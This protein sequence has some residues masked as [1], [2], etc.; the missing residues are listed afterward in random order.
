[1]SFPDF[2]TFF[3]HAS[4]HS[5][6]PWQERLAATAC[7]GRWP[8][9]I[10]IPTGL[11]KTGTLSIALY[12]LAS[13]VHAGR[14]RTTPQRII[15]VVDRRPVVDQTHLGL[16]S[17]SRQL[18]ASGELAPV[19]AALRRL[20]GPWGQRGDALVVQGI[21]G[22]SRDDRR[23]LRPTG[24]C[25]VT[26]TPHQLVSRLLFRG[27]GVSARTRS[28]HAG[29]LGVDA[30]I[31][32][33]EPH[34]S[35]QAIATVRAVLELQADAGA[36]LGLP[37]SRLVLLGATVPGA[38]DDLGWV[39]GLDEDDRRHSQLE[40]VLPASRPVRLVTSGTS[41]SAVAGAL[42]REYTA[43]RKRF[44]ADRRIAVMANTVSLAQTVRARLCALET[45]QDEAEPP[46]IPLVTS[47]MR[48]H[49][50]TE[51]IGSVT[52]PD[53]A[54]TVVAT[55]SLEVGID[56][57]F[58]TL[59]TEACPYPA[60]VQ[61]L[62]R[63]NRS[64]ESTDA[65]AVVVIGTDPAQVRKGTEAVYGA[66]AVEATTRMLAG[67]AVEGVV[68]LSLARQLEL[69]DVEAASTDLWPAQARLATFHRDYLAVMATTYP[70]PWSDL[71]VDSFVSG[72]DE[73]GLEVLV[74]WRSDLG[75]L[76]SCPPLSAEQV[77]VPLPALRAMLADHA[78]VEVAD[79]D[80]GASVRKPP[81][82]R[83]SAIDARVRR[84]DT[85]LPVQA[86]W[87]LPGDVVVLGCR[88][89]GYLPDAGWTPASST[90]VPDLSLLAALNAGG[91]DRFPVSWESLSPWLATLGL[92]GQDASEG[93]LRAVD[94]VLARLE[95]LDPDE[96]RAEL[97]QAAPS[98]A[99][100]T[101]VF[102]VAG[103]EEGL[104]LLARTPAKDMPGD[105]ASTGN[106]PGLGRHQEQV[107]KEV[108]DAA[109][110]AGM[111]EAVTEAVAVA[112]RWHDE[113][114]S[115]ARFQA[116]LGNPYP[117]DAWAK[118]RRG[119][120][121]PGTD[122]R[123][124]A[125][126]GLPRGWRH[127]GLSAQLCA[128]Q[129]HSE[130]A[131]HLVGSHH[132]RF[133]PLLHADATDDGQAELPARAEAFKRLNAT[134]GPWGLAYLEAMLR[135]SDWHA[136]Q[137]PKHGPVTSELPRGRRTVAVQ[138]GRG[139]C[140]ETVLVGLTPSPLTGWF[141]LAGLLRLV[142]EHD[143]ATTIHWP[144]EGNSPPMAPVWSSS[145]PVAEACRLLTTS[146]QW[147]ELVER[148]RGRTGGLAAKYQKV[149]A[150]Q[151]DLR[152]A[153]DMGAWLVTGILQD[154]A[155]ADGQRL[156]LSIPAQANNAS[157][158][159]TALDVCRDGSSPGQ[160]APEL[161][162]CL[163]DPLSGWREAQCDGGMDRAGTEDGVTGR[164]VK[165]HR[166]IRAELAPAALMGMASMGAVGVQGLGVRGRSLRLPLP[167]APVTWP[168]LVA[169]THAVSLD[170]GWVLCY[171]A[172][173]VTAYE[174]LWDGRAQSSRT[175]GN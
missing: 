172:R 10:D 113:G 135:L 119:R 38:R 92:E 173:K 108:L 128:D 73:E 170:Q 168:E 4:G 158:V 103:S 146:D 95:E 87:I 90:P 34:L 155:A 49:D 67:L 142:H 62:G 53:A 98:E 63:L 148:G 115:D 102:E 16:R 35:Q 106:P 132:G 88:V 140:S 101:W 147:R 104:S 32:F 130:L 109:K 126:S 57:S 133:R 163:T 28:L 66:A 47:R 74:A 164:E 31:V 59:I 124:A 161:V 121:S 89:G 171:A 51:A 136:S 30:L 76:D 71:P 145:V 96:I 153:A 64:G 110:A 129:G 99:V 165:N 68:D 118:S 36:E 85:W 50:R 100:E 12:A 117:A 5:P 83:A 70:T 154:A 21:H 169:R 11:G 174:S 150:G 86:T 157:F 94:G 151:V 19:R 175:V 13:Q 82:T 33:D 60:L 1:M 25:V 42:V 69:N 23:W 29:L 93:F 75:V 120:V 18:D 112:A 111:A 56:Q 138:R 107:R 8:D 114:K 17:L 24:A 22:E 40:Q 79:V 125:I 166:M 55:Q 143:S 26:M 14:V 105:S 27:Y 134:W 61:R 39:F 7:D 54:R 116:Y 52:G 84:D 44:G 81:A 46:H 45:R 141:A 144:Q 152:Q 162:R 20:A 48:P 3:T 65:E 91:G 139:G 159:R 123:I 2:P 127:E 6:Y 43:Q 149:D 77:S 78:V 72:P 15:H 37:A 160:G 131:V 156:P 122:R 41:D 58:D 167:A 80:R 9:V 97:T 137:H